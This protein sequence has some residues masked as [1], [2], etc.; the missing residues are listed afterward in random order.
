M[1]ASWEETTR[2]RLPDSPTSPADL[3]PSSGSG[4]ADADGDLPGSDDG[5][6]LS[7]LLQRAPHSADGESDWLCTVAVHGWDTDLSEKEQAF[8]ARLDHQLEEAGL[9][10]S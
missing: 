7:A 6:C 3:V 8:H 2:I 9:S 5:T 1:E 4:A 10:H